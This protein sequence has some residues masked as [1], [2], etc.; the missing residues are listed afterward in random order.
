MV[1]LE[2]NNVSAGYGK[3]EIIHN[4]SFKLEK[5]F[6]L[7]I[8]G[9]NGSGK[10]TLLRVVSRIIK[11]Y[12]GEI[13]FYGTEIRKISNRLL[14]R[15]ISFL[16]SDI[17]I[18]YPY[19]VK[20]LLIMARYPFLTGLQNPSAR[21]LNVINYVIHQMELTKF[22]DRTIFQMSEGEKQRVLLAQ[23]LA[24]EP[25]LLMLD[26][27]TSHLDIGFQFGFLDLL[28]KLQEQ[29]SLSILAVL[30]DLNLAS[31]YCDNLLLLENGSIV[32]FGD[33]KDVIK[34][35]IIEKV[36]KTN[37]LVY[38]HPISKKPYVFGV[39]ECWKNLT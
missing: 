35:E 29:S 20:E 1:I 36:Y 6:F 17:E 24:Q 21:D 13:F 5:G 25:E 9:P 11:K 14:S 34:F 39:P 10:S 30:H 18:A 32:K 12:K 15:K 26:E 7:G 23:C 19:T 16:P 22:L 8:I 37:V 33:V 38:P 27:P 3:D 2:L 31:Q 4:I 28:K